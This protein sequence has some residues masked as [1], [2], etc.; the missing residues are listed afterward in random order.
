METVSK[1]ISAAPVDIGNRTIRFCISSEVEDRDEDVVIASGAQL[2]NYRKNPA[3]LGFHNICDF[4]LGKTLNVWVDQ[5]AHKVYQDV[6]FPT[7]E[8]LATDPEQASEKAKVVDTTYC[9]YK[10]GMLNAVSV[11]FRPLEMKP[12]PNSKSGWGKIIEKW[13]LYETS[14]VPVPA[15]PDALAEAMKSVSASAN[16]A[17]S[18]G[19]LVLKS[20]GRGG[21]EKGAIP[22]KKHPLADEDT[23]W[24]AA[25]ETKDAIPE[26]LKEMCAWYDSDNPDESGSY[27]LPHHERDGYKTVWKGVAAAMGALLGARG[28]VNVPE[29]DVEKVKAHLVKHY[30]DFGKDV[31]EDKA[32]WEAQVKAELEAESKDVESVL[33]ITKSGRRLSAATLKAI[34]ALDKLHTDHAEVT[35]AY[36]AAVAKCMKE[37][38]YDGE[39]ENEDEDQEP[40]DDV[41]IEVEQE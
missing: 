22:Y 20:I 14:A 38:R 35:K 13:E 16:F 21:V 41:G 24:D 12:N 39:D 32:A 5:V 29:V 33:L 8:E 26:E 4:P 27:K 23:A 15:N 36:H 3:F 6:Y 1:I 19:E 31:P 17:P 25:K 7:V 18:V 2:D 34:D 40:D 10:L 9:M 30:A 11:Q 28:G 37:L